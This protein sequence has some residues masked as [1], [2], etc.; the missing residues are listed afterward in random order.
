MDPRGGLHPITSSYHGR[1]A[2]S[3]GTTACTGPL[4]TTREVVATPEAKALLHAKSGAVAADMESSFIVAQAAS[5]G[6]PVLVIRAVLDGAGEGLA[7]ELTRLVTPEGNLRLTRALALSVTRPAV[8][9]GAL[10]LRRRTHQAL[11]AVARVLAA[12]VE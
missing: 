5:F 9:P 1:A 4:I 7:P 11:R 3:A 10:T 2:A 6:C 8:L 12:L